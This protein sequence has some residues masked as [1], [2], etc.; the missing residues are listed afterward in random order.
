MNPTNDDSSDDES[1]TTKNVVLQSQSSEQVPS[2]TDCRYNQTPYLR[3]DHDISTHHIRNEKLKN[4]AANEP[5][6]ERLYGL[7]PR[8]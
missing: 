1:E 8:S 3:Y 2:T 7:V 4:W 5:T 6:K